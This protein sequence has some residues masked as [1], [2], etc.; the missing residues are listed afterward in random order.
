[1]ASLVLTDSSQLTSDS[2]HLGVTPQTIRPLRR[3]EKCPSMLVNAVR[4]LTDISVLEHPVPTTK[5]QL[6]RHLPEQLPANIQL[7]IV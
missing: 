6:P 2:Q 4:V 7:S 5:E 1:M 3:A